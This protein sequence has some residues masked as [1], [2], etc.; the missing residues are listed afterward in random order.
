MGLAAQ[1]AANT[2]TEAGSDFSLHKS[3]HGRHMLAEM[4]L[5]LRAARTTGIL[6][7]TFRTDA[8]ALYINEGDIVF[9]TS[10][11]EEDRMGDML[12]R[13][14]RITHQQHDDAA[15]I[16]E[17]TGKRIGQVLVEGGIISP[18]DLIWAVQHQVEQIVISLFDLPGGSLSMKP[19]RLP[20]NE[21]ITLRLS[22]GNLIYRGSKAIKE[23]SR[24]RSGAPSLATILVYA[25]DPLLLYQDISL[26]END[27]KLLTLVDGKRTIN[28]IV[29]AAPVGMSSDDALRTVY[30]LYNAALLEAVSGNSDRTGPDLN[31]VCGHV[32]G[33]I[34]SETLARIEKMYA[35]HR[36]LGYH[37]V[38][39]VGHNATKEEIKRAYYRMAKE[40]HPDRH[41]HSQDETLA[42]KLSTIFTYV[43]LAYRTLS[44]AGPAR[45]REKVAEPG[46]AQDSR[47]QDPRY[48]ANIKFHEAMDAIYKGN[49]NEAA[50][51]LRQAIH[52]NGSEP[53]Y[54]YYCGVAMRK[55]Q[56]I[57][58]AEEAL[59]KAMLLNPY[60]A[61]YAAELGDIYL[62]LGFKSRATTTYER[63]IGINPSCEKA[64]EGLRLA[65]AL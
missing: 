42:L 2:A 21:I 41:L 28:K 24:M 18:Q 54:H 31:D 7:A 33:E 29:A 64:I 10:T 50:T 55:M 56:K 27:R 13:A 6:S 19:E 48:L 8:I 22:T 9:A 37:G 49:Y 44:G 51:L 63:A 12:V 15:S 47:T 1:E 11:R 45:I 25:S 43:N 36:A 16:Q 20:I 57:K 39:G 30:A 14:G 17:A 35:E 46:P 38:L 40:Y 53:D 5:T 60:N 52:L 58:D 23:I 59:K 26:D 65:A 4:L 61:E 62:G 3:R 32:T 34:D